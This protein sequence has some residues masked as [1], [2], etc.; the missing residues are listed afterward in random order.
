[1]WNN[2]YISL[3]MMGQGMFGIFTAILLIMIVIFILGR[4]GT[5]KEEKS[6]EN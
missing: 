6:P 2:F 3:K 1:M 4:T 5:S